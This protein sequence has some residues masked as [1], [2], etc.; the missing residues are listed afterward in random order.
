MCEHEQVKLLL[1]IAVFAVK[2]LCSVG[3]VTLELGAEQ[4]VCVHVVAVRC[5]LPAHCITCRE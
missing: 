2:V 4:Q 1:A 3:D 5:R